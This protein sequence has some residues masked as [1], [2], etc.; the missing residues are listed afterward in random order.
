MEVSAIKSVY[1]SGDNGKHGGFT[2]KLK[3]DRR[4]PELASLGV[5]K[6]LQCTLKNSRAAAQEAT[7]VFIHPS[8]E[9]NRR[10]VKLLPVLLVL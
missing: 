2:K 7:C 3:Y 8:G 6:K 5:K 10:S 4:I 9:T 1:K